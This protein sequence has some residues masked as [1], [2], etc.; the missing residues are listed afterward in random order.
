MDD[1]ANKSSAAISEAAQSAAQAMPVEYT[2]EDFAFQVYI[3][4]EL[5]QNEYE[6]GTKLFTGVKYSY[7]LEDT[8]TFPLKIKDISIMSRLGIQIYSMEAEDIDA[9][10]ASTVIDLFDAHK[11]LR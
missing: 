7:E 8:L 6:E 10:I 9:P 2:L 1:P 5:I 4:V 3:E 11:R